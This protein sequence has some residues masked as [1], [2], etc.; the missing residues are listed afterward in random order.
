[1]PGVAQNSKRTG[2]I[3]SWLPGSY[4]SQKRRS[5]RTNPRKCSSMPGWR[6]LRRC[7]S[8]RC[9]ARIAT[10]PAPE[11][12]DANTS[13]APRLWMR[14][15]PTPTWAWVFTTITWTPSA[16]LPRSCAF[17]W[18]SPEGQSKKECACSNT[19]SRRAFSLLTSRASISR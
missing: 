8:T 6:K 10:R 13:C 16:P 12:A 14:I 2:T 1:M 9:A 19:P 15:S 5:N 7:G 18:A 17:S 11:C 3:L 4:R